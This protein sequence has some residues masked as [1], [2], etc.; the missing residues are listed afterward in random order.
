M[1]LRLENSDSEQ[2]R[3][4]LETRQE[5]PASQYSAGFVWLAAGYGVIDLAP[6]AAV[7][8][9]IPGAGTVAGL[10]NPADG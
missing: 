8:G 9:K 7:P 6:A 3:R 5:F 2:P 1:M 10:G 4:P